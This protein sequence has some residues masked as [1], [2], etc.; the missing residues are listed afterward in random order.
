MC[1]FYI[2]NVAD[3]YKAA[4]CSCFQLLSIIIIIFFFLDKKVVFLLSLKYLCINKTC[5]KKKNKLFFWQFKLCE[6]KRRFTIIFNI[7]F[8]F[9]SQGPMV[10]FNVAMVC[11]AFYMAGI[12]VYAHWAN[13]WMKSIYSN[14]KVKKRKCERKHH[15]Q[16]EVIF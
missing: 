13:I 15:A 9:F 12:I 2:V 3:W 1:L 16:E 10:C 8:V 5:W 7:N 6:L 11:T 14:Q 4:M